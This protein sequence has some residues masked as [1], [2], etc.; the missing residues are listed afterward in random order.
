MGNDGRSYESG[1][2]CGGNTTVPQQ[3]CF[4]LVFMSDHL[5]VI[6]DYR[7]AGAPLNREIAPFTELGLRLGYGHHTWE[8]SWGT[9][10]YTPLTISIIDISGR[11][12]LQKTMFANNGAQEVINYDYLPKGL[13]LLQFQDQAGKLYTQKVLA[14]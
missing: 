1:L 5:P 2:N 10:R 13:Y 4:N 8:L 12:L 14:K 11:T 3:V 9:S 6:A 7:A